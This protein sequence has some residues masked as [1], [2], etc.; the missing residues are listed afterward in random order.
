MGVNPLSLISTIVDLIEPKYWKNGQSSF[1]NFY[2]CRYGVRATRHFLVNPLSLISTI[3]DD[4]NLKRI[5]YVNPLSLISTIVDGTDAL[6]LNAGQSSFFN[7]YYCRYTITASEIT[8]SILF[9]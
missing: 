6:E 3:V 9:L 4:G 2:Y 5:A 1:F 8:A 7:F